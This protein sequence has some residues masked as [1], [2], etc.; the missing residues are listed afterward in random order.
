MGVI[1]RV[2]FFAADITDAYI[3]GFIRKRCFY[4]SAMVHREYGYKKTAVSGTDFKIKEKFEG[5]DLSSVGR[6][7]A[8][9]DY[10]QGVEVEYDGTITVHV[11]REDHWNIRDVLPEGLTVVGG[12]IHPSHT[13]KA[14]A[15]LDIA[16]E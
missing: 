5:T 13:E 11:Q 14:C 7:L 3:V 10:V 12:M 16:R 2:Y 4:P 6:R 8:A 9:R 15:H 1:T